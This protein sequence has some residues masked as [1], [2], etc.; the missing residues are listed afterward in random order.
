M[1]CLFTYIMTTLP[2]LE[3]PWVEGSLLCTIEEFHVGNGFIFI[4]PGDNGTLLAQ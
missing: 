2:L 1:F 3:I 4:S